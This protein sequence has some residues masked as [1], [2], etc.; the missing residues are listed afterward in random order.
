MEKQH[1]HAFNFRAADIKVLISSVEKV[2]SLLFGKFLPWLTPEDKDRERERVAKNV[3]APAVSW[4]LRYCI[5][6]VMTHNGYHNVGRSLCSNCNIACHGSNY[7]RV[8][9]HQSAAHYLDLPKVSLHHQTS[10]F[11]TLYN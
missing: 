3:S 1:W 5:C 4:R 7:L 11:L 9:C 6:S 2:K 10:L 8:F